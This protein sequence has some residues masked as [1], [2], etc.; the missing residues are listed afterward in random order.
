MPACARAHG[1]WGGLEPQE[2]RDLTV[3]ERRVIQLARVYAMVKRVLGKHVPWAKDHEAAIPQ[4]TSHNVVAY[5]HDPGKLMRIIC[6]LPE[7]LAKDFAVQFLRTLEDV[8]QEP[9][10]KVSLQRLRS[11]I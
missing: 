1:L 6:M 9:A 2:I 8:Q 11:A 3:I 5:P 4:Y 7:D 10:L